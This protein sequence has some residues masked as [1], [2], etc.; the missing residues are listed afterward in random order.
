MFR[1]LGVLQSIDTPLKQAAVVALGFFCLALI[2]LIWR[3]EELSDWIYRFKE[4]CG[5]GAENKGKKVN[6]H[7]T[8]CG[9]RN[10][11]GSTTCTKCGSKL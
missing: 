7:C 6:L 9:K 8:S 3:R 2:V 10:R 11:K 5:I 4:R 1:V